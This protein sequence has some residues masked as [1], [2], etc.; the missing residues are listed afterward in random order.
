MSI[1]AS[2]QY[3]ISIA[4][5]SM[6]VV[7]NNPYL[8]IFWIVPL[9][10]TIASNI[11]LE[12]HI[13]IRLCIMCI[14]IFFTAC[15]MH[16]LN[17]I[18]EHKTRSMLQVMHSSLKRIHLLLAWGVISTIFYELVN[19]ETADS[20]WLIFI[21]RWILVLAWPTLTFYV[22]PIIATE[23]MPLARMAQL[24][25]HLLKNSF[26]EVVGG[27]L[28]CGLILIPAGLLNVATIALLYYQHIAL[29]QL[30]A[31]TAICLIY[32]LNIIYSA[33][34]T[35]MLYEEYKKPLANVD[36]WQMPMA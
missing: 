20:S 17:H 24:T 32:L 30:C 29:A 28:Y 11:W 34:K 3:G 14:S 21:A 26:W 23:H 27:S 6:R 36:M 31:L 35:V 15:F 33:F 4:R 9:V 25:I 10:T 7:R 22:L 8:L 12:P 13:T 5:E 16:A 1:V 19:I 2:I 18:L